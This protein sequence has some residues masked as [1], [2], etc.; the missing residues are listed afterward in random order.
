MKI[1]MTSV[2]VDDQDKALAMDR[3]DTPRLHLRPLGEGDE[4]LYCHLYTDPDLMRHIGTPMS[5]DA[6]QRSFHRACGLATQSAPSMQLWVITEHGSPVGLGLLARV[7]HGD[8]VDVAE[9][10]I[11]LAA[12]GQGR[13][14]AAE[15]LGALTDQIFALPEIRMVWTRQSPDNAAV[16][17]LMH[18]LGFERGEAPG[19][20]AVE[21]RWQLDRDRWQARRAPN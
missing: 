21:W 4:A 5:A 3:F 14:L 2:M 18:R 10:G 6:A 9:M 7:R 20:S 11:M 16:V 17:R 19:N 15:A 12:E 13:G 1:Q 8:A